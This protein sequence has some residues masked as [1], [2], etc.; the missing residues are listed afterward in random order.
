ME[1]IFNCFHQY[2]IHHLL[3]E[4][5]LALIESKD[6]YLDIHQQIELYSTWA[7]SWALTK[8]HMGKLILEVIRIE[9]LGVKVIRIDESF[10]AVDDVLNEHMNNSSFWNNDICV[11]NLV[12]FCANPLVRCKQHFV[13]RKIN[14]FDIYSYLL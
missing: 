6:V 5:V 1:D 4:G 13:S 14:T 3:S 9:V 10:R 12:I 2:P 8:G 11:W 7:C